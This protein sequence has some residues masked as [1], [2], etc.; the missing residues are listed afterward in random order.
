L[1]VGIFSNPKL[2]IWANFGWPW[3]EIFGIVYGHFEYFTAIWY[4]MVV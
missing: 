3:D 1:P 4:L 2:Q